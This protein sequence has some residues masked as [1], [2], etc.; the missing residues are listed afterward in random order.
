MKGASILICKEGKMVMGKVLEE[1]QD[2]FLTFGQ[3]NLLSIPHR[4][5]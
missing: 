1:K 5:S 2:L 3:G 4:V